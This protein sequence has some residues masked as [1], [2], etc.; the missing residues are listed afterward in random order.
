MKKKFL[1]PLFALLAALFM[2][3]GHTTHAENLHYS[4]SAQLPSN[5]I[6]SGV[7]YFALKVTPGQKQN[8]GVSIV[9]SDSKAHN[10]RVSVNRAVTNTNGV[11]DY[12][13]RGVKKAPSLQANIEDMTPKAFT[14]NVPANTTKTA[15]I[16]L[17]VPQQPFT[18]V[19]LGGVRVA[20]LDSSTSKKSSKGLSLTNKFAYVIGLA[21]QEDADYSKI[22]PN[23]AM[24]SV[25]AKQMNYRNYITANVEN[26]VPNLMRKLKIT[27][28]VSKRGSSDTLL[29]T[30]K[31]AMAMAPNSMLAFPVSTNNNPLQ[32]G[33]YTMDLEAWAKDDNGNYH[34]HF[35]KNFTIT[36]AKANKLNK[37]AV[38][39][40]KTKPNY[41]LW[42][43]IGIGI[44]ILLI[45]LLILFLLFKRRK[46]DDDEDETK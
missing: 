46:K 25:N 5:Q 32:A 16:A 19:A 8:L 15:T 33:K 26:T 20:E 36:A 39:L 22:K 34:W 21:L 44:L 23:M 14:V 10:Y 27:A 43:L 4:V 35:K 38:E 18:G 13:K 17:T 45:L 2:V 7:S 9:N 11:I 31:S 1:L 40:K 37:T 12:A 29:T 30:T 3:P 6:D 42:I 24:H 41:L 28:K